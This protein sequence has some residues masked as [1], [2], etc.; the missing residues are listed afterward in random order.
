VLRTAG[1]TPANALTIAQ[2]TFTWIG[3][4]LILAGLALAAA[5]RKGWPLRLLMATLVAAAL[6]APAHQAQIHVL[7]S[8]HKHVAFG[9]WFGCLAAGYVLA[10]ATK[11]HIA[12]GIRIIPVTTAIVAFTGIPQATQQF[13]NWANSSRMTQVLE[14]TIKTA[15]CPCLVLQDNV[16]SYYDP[17]QGPYTGAFSFTW[18]H[19]TGMTAYADAIKAGY[20]RT[21]ETDPGESSTTYRVTT[22]ALA[23]NS[24]YRLVWEEPVAWGLMEIWARK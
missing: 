13:Q 18:D 24:N 14:K 17:A 16:A 7:T 2:D 12:K 20:F 21:V 3:S 19:L 4:L 15:G 1:G 11:V 8:L 22:G 23:A 5:W 9:A 10:R 6:A